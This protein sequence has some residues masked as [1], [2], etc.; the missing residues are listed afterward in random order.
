MAKIEIDDADLKRIMKE[1]VNEKFG[2]ANM[3]FGTPGVCRTNSL[4]DIR[5]RLSV[6]IE[7]LQE[8][9][10]ILSSRCDELDNELEETI[11]GELLNLRSIKKH[12]ESANVE[13]A[14]HDLNKALKILDSDI[15]AFEKFVEERYTEE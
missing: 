8:E 12:V 3:P 2:T 5:F 15:S 1:V 11:R 4:D 9:N 6:A 14:D 7:Q 10:S 13:Y